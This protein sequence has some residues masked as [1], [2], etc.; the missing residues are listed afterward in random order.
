VQQ[1]KL[2]AARHLSHISSNMTTS[3]THRSK[4]DPSPHSIVGAKTKLINQS[5]TQH[6]P[7]ALCMEP[8]SSSNGSEHCA[9]IGR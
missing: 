7:T 2:F 4:A 8:S 9:L 5:S 6:G 3:Q 1:A